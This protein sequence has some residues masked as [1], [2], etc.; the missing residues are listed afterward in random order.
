VLHVF[1]RN[2]FEPIK[3]VAECVMQ[4][5]EARNGKLTEDLRETLYKPFDLEELQILLQKRE[6]LTSFEGMD[7]V[8]RFSRRRGR[9][10]RR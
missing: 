9:G 5:V 2:E 3:E 4:M 7:L 10:W 6:G 8:G 1:L